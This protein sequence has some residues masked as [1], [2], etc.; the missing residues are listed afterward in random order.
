MRK[1][2]A[3]VTAAPFADGSRLTIK[4][5]GGEILFVDLPRSE[6]GQLRQDISVAEVA[7]LAVAPVADA[8]FA[9]PHKRNRR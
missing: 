9:T 7:A 8:A 4:T 5:R 1:L 6:A 2:D 3:T